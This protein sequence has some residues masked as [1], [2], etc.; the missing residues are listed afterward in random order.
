MSIQ[1]RKNTNVTLQ[2]IAQKMGTSAMT[3]SRVL[4]GQYEVQTAAAIRRADEIRQVARTMGYVPNAAARMM[5]SKQT[6]QIGLLLRN[7]EGHRYH[8]LAAFILMLGI[9]TRLEEDGYLL[10]VVRL[11]DIRYADG[12]RSRVFEERLLD[13]LIVFGGFSPNVFDWIENVIPNCIW[14]DTNKWLENS[15]L[16]RDEEQVGQL[17]AKHVLNLGYRRVIWTGGHPGIEGHYSIRDRYSGLKN[18]LARHGVEL[19]VMESLQRP[20]NRLIYPQ[21][22]ENLMPDCVLVAY[23]VHGA[24][25]VMSGANSIGKAVGRDFGLVCCDETPEVFESWPGL[26]RASNDRFEM[27]C[28]A[29]D[30]MLQKLRHPSNQPVS[31]KLTSHW[32]AG[33]SAWG[34]LAIR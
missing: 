1:T 25:A 13:G 2:A 21:L 8:N 31:R 19:D 10:S 12:A 23:N 18:E 32:I 28:L 20:D 33:N 17:V 6:R 3:V 9:N 26:S 22:A 29:A 15:C 7:E 4:N 34:P 16:H 24:Q 11:G 27:G 5:R 30:M 14:A